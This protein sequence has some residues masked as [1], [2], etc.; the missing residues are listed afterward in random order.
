MR[1]ELVNIDNEALV[2]HVCQQPVYVSDRQSGS[3]PLHHR[4]WQPRQAW[5]L[6]WVDEWIDAVDEMMVW[7]QMISDRWMQM[8]FENV[9]RR[10]EENWRRLRAGIVLYRQAPLRWK[11][12]TCFDL[13][14]WQPEAFSSPEQQRRAGTDNLSIYSTF[15]AMLINT[16]VSSSEYSAPMAA[17]SIWATYDLLGFAGCLHIS[18]A[19]KFTLPTRYV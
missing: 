16:L 12:R 9:L 19:S 8:S 13:T 1:L 17:E 15:S 7:A 4:C 3:V 18:S 10:R 6:G 14:S 5:L 11:A 2:L